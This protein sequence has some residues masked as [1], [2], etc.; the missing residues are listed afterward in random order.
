VNNNIL[1]NKSLKTDFENN[2]FIEAYSNFLQTTGMLAANNF[3]NGITQDDYKN[4][5]TIFFFNTTSDTSSDAHFDL[6]RN[7]NIRIELTFDQPLKKSVNVVLIASKPSIIKVDA[8][9]NLTIE[10]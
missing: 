9:R 8:N 3:T 10:N 4:G 1:T 7:G 5:K 2:Q 6:V